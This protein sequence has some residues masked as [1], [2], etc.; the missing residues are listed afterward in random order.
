[1]KKIINIIF[2]TVVTLTSVFSQ[3]V[4]CDDIIKVPVI[5]DTIHLDN[6]PPVVPPYPPVDPPPTPPGTN[7]PIR[8]IFWV[9]GMKGDA[10]SWAS[11]ASWASNEYKVESDVFDYSDFQ[12]TLK[13]SIFGADTKIHDEWLNDKADYPYLD[14]S[15]NYVIAHSFGGVV[16]RGV[17]EKNDKSVND[18]NG[19][20]TFA[21]P[22]GGSRMAPAVKTAYELGS[23]SETPEYDELVTMVESACTDWASGPAKEAVTDNFFGNLFDYF[24]LIETDDIAAQLCATAASSASKFIIKTLAPAAVHQLDKGSPDLNINDLINHKINFYGL[25]DGFG[26]NSA[27]RMF[28]SG[29]HPVNNEGLFNAGGQDAQALEALD[30]QVNNYNAKYQLYKFYY[31]LKPWFAPG[32]AFACG[33]VPYLP[34]KKWNTLKEIRDDY[35]KGYTRF[36]KLN[37]DWE[38]FT[39][40][41]SVTVE[42]EYGDCWEYEY[43]VEWDDYIETLV[44]E[45]VTESECNGSSTY[46]TPYI[47]VNTSDYDGFLTESS[48]TDWA[49]EKHIPLSGSNHLQIRNDYNTEKAL[50]M[51]FENNTGSFKWFNLEKK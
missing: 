51:V 23:N 48:T 13:N 40:A 20:V 4:I 37:N 39:G 30:A 10:G 24:G 11:A 47:I 50:K 38:A 2:V 42:S 26:E 16:S 19:L 25:E 43:V 32:W 46:W 27:Y 28:Y 17:N 3:I 45:N 34:C 21:S 7:D 1:M 14:P 5:T 35:Y 12:S 18:W 6:K 8:V 9:H 22:H 44:A 49:A 31:D 29:T 33:T 41:Q 36:N 15:Y